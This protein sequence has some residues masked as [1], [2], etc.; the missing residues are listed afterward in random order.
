MMIIIII[1]CPFPSNGAPVEWN[2][3]G[4]T[5]VLGE[6]PVPGPLCPTQTPHGLTRHRTRA[7]AVGGRWL[8]AW[9]MALQIKAYK[10]SRCTAVLI[11]SLRGTQ[12][13]AS[14]LFRFI[15]GKE[16]RNSFTR[17]ISGPQNQSESSEGKYVLSLSMFVSWTVQ[18]LAESLHR[19]HYPGYT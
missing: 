2:W 3:Q 16:R 11:L 10:G 19:L 18:P 13:L 12:W 15:P 14:R 1:I 7:S 5:E 4:K 8:T 6:K 17:R 9:A